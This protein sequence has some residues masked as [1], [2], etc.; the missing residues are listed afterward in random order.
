MK[1]RLF[2]CSLSLLLI[3]PLGSLPR[4][5]LGYAFRSPS[6]VEQLVSDMLWAQPEVTQELEHRYEE[7]CRDML[8]NCGVAP[9]EGLHCQVQCQ[10]TLVEWLGLDVRSL[11]DVYLI[12]EPEVT[13][14]VV[15]DSLPIPQRCRRA[16]PEGAVP[17]VEPF[18]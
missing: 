17:R 5:P 11:E 12:Q 15:A 18:K 3:L 10:R 14:K 2:I 8:L 13:P 1:A 9:V 16:H 4:T 7:H 6:L